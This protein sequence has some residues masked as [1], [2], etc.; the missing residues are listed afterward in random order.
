MLGRAC[1]LFQFA[2]G[3]GGAEERFGGGHRAGDDES[4]GV[5]Y[6]HKRLGRI[7]GLAGPEAAL[8][9]ARLGCQVDLYEMRRLVDGKPLL[10][11]KP[12][13]ANPHFI[14]RSLA[15]R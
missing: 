6:L 12:R 2:R 9:A 4:G 8:T 7:G 5:D 14:A 1:R 11:G 10:Y 13:F 15:A 3:V